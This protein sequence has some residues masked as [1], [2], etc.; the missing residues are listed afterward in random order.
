MIKTHKIVLISLLSIVV[1]S[2]YGMNADN[3]DD[4]K[5]NPFKIESNINSNE[6]EIPTNQGL[7]AN[8]DETEE[9][10]LERMKYSENWGFKEICEEFIN[11]SKKGYTIALGDAPNEILS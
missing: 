1:T 8:A 6:N 3:Q 7:R 5:Q 4:I 10:L 9:A 11:A 2:A